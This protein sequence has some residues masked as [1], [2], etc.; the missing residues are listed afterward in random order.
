MADPY[1]VQAASDYNVPLGVLEGIAAS[2]AQTWDT[3]AP[4]EGSVGR[5]QIHPIHAPEIMQKYG[6]TMQQLAQRPDVQIAYWAPRIA[7]VW[8]NNISQG[9][10]AAAVAVVNQVQ[11]PAEQYRQR[12][13]SN[14]MA[15][16][17]QSGATTPQGGGNMT[18]PTT[19]TS[20]SRT[21]ESF[22]E[23]V[24]R[25]YGF[26]DMD[27]PAEPGA[28]YTGAQQAQDFLEG[29]TPTFAASLSD[30]FRGKGATAGMT[31]YESRNIGVA[32]AGEARLQRG[33]A[34]DMDTWVDQFAADEAQRGKGWALQAFAD[35]ISAAQE[36]RTQAEAAVEYESQFAPVGMTTL[37]YT[38]EQSAAATYAKGMGMDYQPKPAVQLPTTSMPRSYQ[39]AM[40]M[41]TPE[42]PEYAPALP[43]TATPQYP[44]ATPPEYT[45]P[46]SS[47]ALP[48]PY[49]G[50][51]ADVMS[52]VP[53]G[54]GMNYTP[55]PTPGGG[56]F[57]IEAL[58][59]AM[60]RWQANR[61]RLG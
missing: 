21:G 33:Q 26:S 15:A 53:V 57:T 17:G 48:S 46:T 20:G 39:D 43:T 45:A 44:P 7:A 16:L 31:E 54:G 14:I 42:T 3:I 9:A 19:T 59:E 6:L 12:E 30:E 23:W 56:T 47:S 25:I 34:W 13:V 41:M 18:T 32:E 24:A 8:N 50:Q 38:G 61:L 28:T 52:G 27:D 22:L 36:G 37:P 55:M 10:T 5:F 40:A 51:S 49:T 29:Q 11:A 35:K 58:R 2:E 4:G 60:R 1:L